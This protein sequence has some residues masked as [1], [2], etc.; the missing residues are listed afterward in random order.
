MQSD[1]IYKALGD[2]NRR[3]II[4]ILKDKDMSV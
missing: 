2:K 1:T 3:K 4:E